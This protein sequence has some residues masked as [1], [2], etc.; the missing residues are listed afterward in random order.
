MNIFV[1]LVLVILSF[2][3]SFFMGVKTNKL[4]DELGFFFFVLNLAFVLFLFGVFIGTVISGNWNIG[5]YLLFVDITYLAGY[6]E[7]VIY[8]SG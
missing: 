4:D 3:L 5:L 1:A 7:G 6:I 8:G 2:V